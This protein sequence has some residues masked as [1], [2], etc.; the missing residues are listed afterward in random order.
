MIC[1]PIK[2]I[3][4]QLSFIVRLRYNSICLGHMDWV[5]TMDKSNS[6]ALE[7]LFEIKLFVHDF[8]EQMLSGVWYS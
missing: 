6:R 4:V 3:V 5:A 7:I 1:E 2:V 8:E